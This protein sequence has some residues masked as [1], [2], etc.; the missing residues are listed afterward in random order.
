MIQPTAEQWIINIDLRPG[1]AVRQLEEALIS[2]KEEQGEGEIAS[3]IRNPGEAISGLSDSDRGTVA[4]AVMKR[5]KAIKA[6]IEKGT[7]ANVLL[8]MIPNR[9]WPIAV[10]V[11]EE[12]TKEAETGSDSDKEMT[13]WQPQSAS[14]STSDTMA[15]VP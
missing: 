9:R 2:I 12:T 13:T 6:G 14:S 11:A 15:A 4:S 5:V 1:A 10:L 7:R 3:I 8:N